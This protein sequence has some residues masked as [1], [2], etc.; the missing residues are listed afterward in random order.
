M[1]D[2]SQEPLPVTPAAA[3]DREMT[4]EKKEA[5]K[6][7]LNTLGPKL[8]QKYG[9]RPS[10]TPRQVQSTAADAGLS[11][12]Y[13]CFAYMMYCSPAD[14]SA[15]HAAAGEACDAAA[16]RLAVADEFFGGNV[17]FDAVALADGL[18]GGVVSVAETGAHVLVSV[19]HTGA[20][21]VV[22]LASVGADV[23]TTVVSTGAGAVGQV[24]GV[25]ADGVGTVFGWLGDV[26]WGSLIPTDL[27]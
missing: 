4:P 18:S 24:G 6:S 8:K 13:L 7:Y 21:V 15:L 16:M 9:V 1:P 10:Y 26:D 3:C 14:F 23:V 12:D 20:E 25:M 19:A 22:Q 17:G 5:V 2:T 27:G 11:I